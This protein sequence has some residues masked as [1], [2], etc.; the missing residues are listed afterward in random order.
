MKVIK[1]II[2][3]YKTIKG[4]KEFEPQGSSFYLVGGNGVG[5]SSVGRVLIEMLTKNLPKN[6]ITTGEK[7]G[8]VEVSLDTGQKLYYKF[9]DGKKPVVELITADGFNVAAPKELFEKLAGKGM[10]FDIDEFL[11]MQPKPRRTLLESII[12]VDLTA[13]NAKE[14]EAEEIRKQVKKQYS[15][16]LARV[17]P[18]DEK[19]LK[20]DKI[21]TAEVSKQLED[22][23]QL[24]NDI[25]N[26]KS[27]VETIVTS[28]NAIEEQIRDLQKQLEDNR[29]QIEVHQT[30]LNSKKEVTADEIQA[31]RDKIS[32]A[33]AHN[34]S[35][36]DAQR[37]QKEYDLAKE[38]EAKAEKAEANVKAIREQKDEMLKSNPLPAE[39]MTF[40]EDGDTILL[41]GL[42]FDDNQ[43][44]TSRKCIA[45]LQIAERMIGD[46]KF[47]HFDASI[48]DRTNAEKVLDWADSKGLQ[49]CMERALW[50]GGELK[51]EIHEE[52]TTA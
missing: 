37:N 40:S 16:Q 35:I 26:T 46:I 5:K 22:A 11:K 1:F 27:K 14:K 45:A 51:M 31:L 10:T 39:G 41:D 38:F 48:L 36:D 42:P 32:N 12:G 34:K 3:N 28:N 52:T 21:D 23:N 15:E 2:E 33:D 19:Y 44:A 50:E 9:V 29:A 7:E 18:I 49:L 17:E 43:I 30:Y 24:N 6:P 13:L 47:L 4:R 8:F 25:A 20:A